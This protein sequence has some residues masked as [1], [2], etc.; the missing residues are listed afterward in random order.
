M[1]G[2]TLLA[3]VAT[4]A[5]GGAV[6]ADT[7]VLVLAAED[8]VLNLPISPDVDRVVSDLQ[9]E[10]ERIATAATDSR[11]A[12]A[13]LRIRD[14]TATLRSVAAAP[15][16]MF[17]NGEAAAT[18]TAVYDI[19]LDTDIVTVVVTT[20]ELVPAY[21]AT[22]VSRDHEDGHAHINRSVARRC[23]AEALAAGVEADR[24]GS[25]LI[26]GMIA[27][28]SDAADAVHTEYHRTVSGLSYGSHQRAA[29]RALETVNPCR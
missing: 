5:T 13:V 20:V 17:D 14:D 28:M 3:V 7:R 21:G 12:A 11:I 27:Y 22:A 18:A 6:T 16:D 26:N 2:V 9:T 23:A 24:R 8:P 15:V 1:L 10:L 29:A 4:T 19:S 25:L